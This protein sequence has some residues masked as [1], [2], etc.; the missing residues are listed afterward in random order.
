[1]DR[2]FPANGWDLEEYA[3]EETETWMLDTEKCRKKRH[4]G[5]GKHFLI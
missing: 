3:D 1:V 2:Q 5:G 4:G